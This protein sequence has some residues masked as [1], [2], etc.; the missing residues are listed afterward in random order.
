MIWHVICLREIS[1]KVPTTCTPTLSGN[2]GSN[3]HG[4]KTVAFIY[5]PEH[6][7]PTRRGMGL[8]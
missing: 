4:V 2:I 3:Q 5:K 6:R 7:I 1:R 8:N